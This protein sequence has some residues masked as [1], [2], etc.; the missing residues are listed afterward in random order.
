MNHPNFLQ[1]RAN[2]RLIRLRPEAFS[3]KAVMALMGNFLVGTFRF[4][5][6][7][8]GC[9]AA[10]SLAGMLWLLSTAGCSSNHLPPYVNEGTT[11]V[12][13]VDAG[14]S[15]LTSAGATCT[16]PASGC[17][18]DK[19]GAVTECGSVLRTSGTQVDCSMGNRTCSHGMWGTCVGDHV[20]TQSLNPSRTR[21]SNLAASAVTCPDNPCDPACNRYLDSAPGV[22]AG[23]NT[24]LDVTDAGLALQ[25]V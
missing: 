20:T 19:E 8:R 17:P 22:D 6:R 4:L 21:L 10:T 3:D 23:A 18:C 12:S 9:A 13:N 14:T 15:A 24:A 1:W 2:L 7:D 11:R 5:S 25:P 16:S